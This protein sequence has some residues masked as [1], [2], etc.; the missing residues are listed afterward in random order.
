MHAGHISL[1][2]SYLKCK[3]VDNVIVIIGSGVRDD[4]DQNIAYEIAT[5][6][7][8]S[9]DKVIIRKSVKSSPISDTYDII[10]NAESGTFVMAASKKGSDYKRIN[11]II[12]EY[13]FGGKYYNNI[14][15]DVKVAG[16]FIGCSPLIY[17]GRKDKFNGEPISATIL[18]NDL[19]TN[20]FEHFKTNYKGY[21]IT[22]IQEIWNILK[23]EAMQ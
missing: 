18:R 11:K 1:I 19:L 7:L 15:K 8:A 3:D 22:T 13:S 2:K 5:K 23:K 9:Y 4:I 17:E 12:N 14:S 20:N 21:N 10:E 6:L 16:L